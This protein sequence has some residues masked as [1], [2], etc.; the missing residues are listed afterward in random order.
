[1]PTESEFSTLEAVAAVLKP[2]SIL[3]DALSGDEVTALALRLILKHIMGTHLLICD[4]DSVFV[5]EM[6]ERIKRNLETR[7]E[8]ASVSQLIDK[9]LLWTLVSK[10]N[11]SMTRSLLWQK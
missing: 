4:E 5:S 11:M 7:Y 2:L 8:L 6:K 10:Q 3:T 9:V 1:M